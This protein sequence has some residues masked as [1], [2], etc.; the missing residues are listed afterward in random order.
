MTR[1]QMRTRTRMTMGMYARS[2]SAHRP[3]GPHPQHAN[4]HFAWVQQKEQK[5]KRIEYTHAGSSLTH[6][7]AL[8]CCVFSLPE[9]MDEDSAERDLSVSGGIAMGDCGTR[10]RAADHK[11]KVGTIMPTL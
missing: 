2:A 6:V 4:I 1:M 3:S 9:S 10:I 5:Q 8:L 7:G 11:T